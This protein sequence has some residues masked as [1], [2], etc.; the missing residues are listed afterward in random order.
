MEIFVVIII[1]LIV[2]GIV[3]ILQAQERER[4]L[5]AL[6]LADI[7]NMTGIQFEHYVAKL[8]THQGYKT[9]VTAGSRDF[10]VDVIAQ[11]Q[12]VKYAIQVKRQAKNVSRRAVSDTVTGKFHYGCTSAMVVTNVFFTAGAQELAKSTGCRLVDRK[13]LTNWILAFQQHR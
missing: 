12:A 5:R 13:E 8:L 11:K 2:W 9:Q 3:S 10:G 4:R 7:D 6:Q 1:G